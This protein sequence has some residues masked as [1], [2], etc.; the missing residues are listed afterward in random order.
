VTVSPQKRNAWGKKL[1][2][3]AKAEQRAHEDTLVGIYQA[4]Q[5]EVS[6][7]EIAFR[8]GFKSASNITQKAAAGKAIVERRK[9]SRGGS[10]TP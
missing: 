5:N 8:L 1:E 2:G 4:S 10:S 9:G 6:N 3:L 7:A